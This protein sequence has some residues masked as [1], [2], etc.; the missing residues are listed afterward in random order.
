MSDTLKDSIAELI[1]KKPSD[2]KPEASGNLFRTWHTYLAEQGMELKAHNARQHVQGRHIVLYSDV[3]G[4][5]QAVL[6]D[7]EAASKVEPISRLS[8]SKADKDTKDAKAGDQ[9]AA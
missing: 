3:R 9:K 6:S 5:T 1:G 8:I 4:N 7:S 2:L